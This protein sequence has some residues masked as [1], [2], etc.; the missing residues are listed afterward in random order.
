MSTTSTERMRERRRRRARR[1]VQLTIVLHQD[2]LAEIVSAPKAAVNELVPTL[3]GGGP[4]VAEPDTIRNAT[5][6]ALKILQS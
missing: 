4:D 3:S 2:D 5:V 6:A 1:E